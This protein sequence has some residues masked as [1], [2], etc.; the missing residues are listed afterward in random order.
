MECLLKA[1][2][3]PAIMPIIGSGDIQ[4]VILSNEFDFTEATFADVK[5]F[6]NVDYYKFPID[7]RSVLLNKAYILHGAQKTNKL[8][9][10]PAQRIWN[11]FIFDMNKLDPDKDV[12]FIYS[13][14]RIDRLIRSGFFE[15]V[16]G[17]FPHV[18]HVAYWDDLV[19]ENQ[20][21]A[22]EY[23]KAHF[24]YVFTYDEK[25]AARYGIRYYPSF[26]SRMELS[27]K[28]VDDP[29]YDIC[30]VG[31]AKN[32]LRDI[33]NAYEALSSGG[34]RCSFVV[35]G[36]NANDVKRLPMVEFNKPMSYRSVIE[37]VLA[38]R[39]ILEISQK[40]A[41]GQSLRVN[42][43]VIYHKRLLSNN[44]NIRNLP[45]FNAEYMR[46]Y[47]GRI[48]K[49]DIEFVKCNSSIEPFYDAKLLSPVRF[50]ET[51]DGILGDQGE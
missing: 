3:E 39:C 29:Q 35:N 4:Y 12:C 40:G 1:K 27:E 34:C 17:M 41:S 48:T 7:T 25:E 26:Y 38:S 15:F 19:K 30:F 23:A 18:Y 32:R 46:V 50:L 5:Q 33:Y 2:K 11:R 43:A 51:I 44:P 22:L 8:F 6:D 9:R 20:K 14:R 10:L 24:D 28:A 36:V 31:Q 49:S 45:Q 42:E 37:L 21:G 16:N 13:F 47:D